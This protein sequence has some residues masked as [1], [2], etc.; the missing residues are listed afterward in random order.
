MPRISPSIFELAFM[1][2]EQ[3]GN[4]GAT[5]TEI[6]QAVILVR[7]PEVKLSTIRSVIYRRLPVE[8]RYLA[9]FEKNYRNGQNYYRLIK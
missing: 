6:Y 1:F 3:K 7:G 9:K 2:L 8:N 4:D 5:M